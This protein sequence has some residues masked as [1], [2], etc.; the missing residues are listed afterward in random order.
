MATQAPS[1]AE[2]A[3]NAGSASAGQPV[4]AGPLIRVVNANGA[5]KIDEALG[6]LKSVDVADVDLLLTFGNGDHGGQRCA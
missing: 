4:I 2:D 5:V 1:K 3:A 6:A